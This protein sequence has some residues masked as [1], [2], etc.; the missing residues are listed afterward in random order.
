MTPVP[1]FRAS[2]VNVDARVDRELVLHFGDAGG[3]AGGARGI[4]HLGVRADGA[5]QDRLIALDLDADALSVELGTPFQRLPD[6]LLHVGWGRPRPHSDQVRHALDAREVADRPLGG[7][8]LV[9]P[10]HLTLERE[11][12]K[13]TRLNSS[14][15][16]IS[17]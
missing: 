2:D 9:E 17:Y 11:D 6:P 13:S 7:L 14:H 15:L 10:I 12:R 8:L 4:P 5:A 1:P 16:V 3:I